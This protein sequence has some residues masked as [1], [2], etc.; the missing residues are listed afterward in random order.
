MHAVIA[1]LRALFGNRIACIRPW[2]RP[3]M[4]GTPPSARRLSV[5]PEDPA[6]HASRFAEDWADIAEFY[7]QK[8]MRELGVPEH[9]IGY[10]DPR[11]GT[12]QVFFPRERQS[13]QASV[14]GQTSTTRAMTHAVTIGHLDPQAI[15]NRT[16]IVLRPLDVLDAGR[17]LGPGH[18]PVEDGD[19]V[20]QF[21][22]LTHERWADEIRPAYDQDSHD[23]WSILLRVS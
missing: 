17:Q 10:A 7:I 12:K 20:P 14:D 1:A 22:E 16:A 3:A 21:E 15:R 8:R 5:V 18:S 19:L 4:I 23:Q 9:Q 13:G 2:K 11:S 6:E